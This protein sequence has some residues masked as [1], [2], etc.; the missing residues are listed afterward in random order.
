MTG[1]ERTPSPWVEMSAVLIPKTKKAIDH[2][3]LDILVD[4][5][6]KY[7]KIIV[8]TSDTAAVIPNNIP[9]YIFSLLI[10]AE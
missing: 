2:N 4:F 5:A 10:S 6:N 9:L 3:S 1:W 7:P 8:A